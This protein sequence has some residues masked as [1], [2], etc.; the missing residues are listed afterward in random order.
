[1]SKFEVL[2][3][4]LEEH[5]AFQAWCRVQSARAAPHT[6]E[7]MKRG[8]KVNVYRLT[9]VGPDGTAVIAK[10]CGSAKA[11]VERLVYE[12]ILPLLPVTGLRCR[13]FLQESDDFCWLFM[14]DAAGELYSQERS[15]HRSLAGRWLAEL[16]NVTLPASVWTRLPNRE[17][18][19]YLN[20]LRGSRATLLHHL[21][22]NPL[23]F[24]DARAIFHSVVKHYDVLESRWHDVQ[25]I[26]DV[27]PR[28]VVHD[29]FVMKNMRVRYGA[30]GPELLVFDWEY[31]GWGMPGA[32]LAQYVDKAISPDLNVYYSARKFA[33]SPLDLRDVQRAGVC[34]GFLRLLDMIAWAISELAFGS[35]RYLL[36][37]V[38]LLQDYDVTLVNALNALQWGDHD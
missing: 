14:D 29:D 27:M 2:T 12:E 32:D 9:G 33:S 13:G 20:L 38:A 5:Q 36:K 15:E 28:T 19:H 22:D 25:S 35:D 8:K 7:A 17:L 24:D 3:D 34:G 1:M 18:G 4:R 11:R 21:A 6:I 30:T 37:P 23:L 26:C 16:H 31:A 10:R